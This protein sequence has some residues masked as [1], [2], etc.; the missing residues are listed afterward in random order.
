LA[1][2]VS[3][4]ARLGLMHYINFRACWRDPY[5]QRRA[6]YHRRYIPVLLPLEALEEV[7]NEYIRAKK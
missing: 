7:V 3:L 2:R 4:E 1:L 6:I 5:L